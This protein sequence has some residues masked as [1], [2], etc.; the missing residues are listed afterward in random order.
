M[1]IDENKEK[2]SNS[3]KNLINSFLI[4]APCYAIFILVKTTDSKILKEIIDIASITFIGLVMFGLFWFAAFIIMIIIKSIK[5][6]ID[7]EKRRK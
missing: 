4:A 5:E 3:K 2:V 6:D 7:Y 1:K